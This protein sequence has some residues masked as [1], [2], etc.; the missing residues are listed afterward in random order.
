MNTGRVKMKGSCQKTKKKP[1]LKRPVFTFVNHTTRTDY[2]LGNNYTI[3]IRDVVHTVNHSH[4][5]RNHV[6]KAVIAKQFC[7]LGTSEFGCIVILGAGIMISFCNN[8]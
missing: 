8:Y 7:R 1:K 4:I 5:S 3:L 6:G 2:V